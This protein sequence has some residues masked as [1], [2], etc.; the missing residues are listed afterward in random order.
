MK[1]VFSFLF[2]FYQYLI[3]LPLGIVATVITSLVTLLFAYTSNSAK[4]KNTPASYWGRFMCYISFMSVSV[5]GMENIE[6]DKSY[7]F[8]AN[9]QSAFDIWVIYGWIG[10]PFSWI[11]KKELGD[12]PLLGSACRSIG[13][14]MIDRSNPAEAK[15]SIE[16]AKEVLSKGGNVVIFPEG[17]R[18]KTGKV[19]I[20]K[21][22]AFTLASD[23]GLPIVPISIIGAYGRITEGFPRIIPGKIKMVIHPPV[24]SK[25][26]LT[27][28]EMRQLSAEVRDIVIAGME[29]G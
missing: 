29:K 11:M 1:R 17:T 3:F 15:K 10:R 9:H 4:L 16:A 28:P 12:I 25:T 21:R 7:I 20:F 14:I 13:H 6:E 2:L 5:E 26:D 23:L 24:Y 22:G 19:G 27:E 18:S 8:A